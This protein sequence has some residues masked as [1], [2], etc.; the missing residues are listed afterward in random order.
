MQ[1]YMPARGVFTSI[2]QPLVSSQ[3]HPKP[4]TLRNIHDFRQSPESDRKPQ[5]PWPVWVTRAATD[6]HVPHTWLKLSDGRRPPC[7]RGRD[8]AGQPALHPGEALGGRK[9]ELPPAAHGITKELP[10]TTLVLPSPKDARRALSDARP[11]R[12]TRKFRSLP[13]FRVVRYDGPCMFL[14]NSHVLYKSIHVF[15]YIYRLLIIRVLC[16][17][18]V[19]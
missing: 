12:R 14:Y 8:D 2:R 9:K 3:I 4:C 19:C 10:P 7:P 18:I 15:L 6:R 11:P 16:W 17:A 1:V 5:P 13:G